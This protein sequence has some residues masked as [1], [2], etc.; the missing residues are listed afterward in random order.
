MSFLWVALGGALGA[1]ARYALA[2]AVVRAGLSFPFATLAANTLGCF[3]MGMLSVAFAT[4][5]SA[6]ALPLGMMTGFLGA[7][8]T[9]SAFALDINHL[10]RESLLLALLY[11]V[12]SLFFS[13]AG[14]AVG[15]GI[16]YWG[17]RL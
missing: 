6:G 3:L 8:T 11:G 1:T 10:L 17:A 5:L 9:F 16:V 15:G 7:F 4:R 13:L 2:L 12:A 14:F